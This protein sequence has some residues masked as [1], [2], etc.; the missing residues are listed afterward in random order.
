MGAAASMVAQEELVHPI[1]CSDIGSRKADAVA[2]LVR[3]RELLRIHCT[4]TK[5]EDASD[6]DDREDAI[7]ELTAIR[8]ALRLQTATARRTERPG[9]VY[10]DPVVKPTPQVFTSKKDPT[11][12]R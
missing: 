11:C 10:L 9:F 5:P 4:C 6:V 3:V 2:E 8:S 12:R 1:D 7:A